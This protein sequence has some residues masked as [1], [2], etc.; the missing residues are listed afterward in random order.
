MATSN[1]E[2]EQPTVEDQSVET[3]IERWQNGD[4]PIDAGEV[5]KAGTE[6]IEVKYEG[7]DGILTVT[8]NLAEELAFRSDVEGS[9][10]FNI[11]DEEAD[12]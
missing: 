8:Y 10:R 11:L 7:S 3:L 6:T 9:G 12:Q 5:R 1:S 2:S 4:L